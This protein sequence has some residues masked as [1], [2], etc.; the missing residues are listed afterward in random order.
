[1][2]IIKKKGNLSESVFHIIS[3]TMDQKEIILKTSLCVKN[4]LTLLYENAGETLI[5]IL[6]PIYNKDYAK[7]GNLNYVYLNKNKTEV[8]PNFNFFITTKIPKPHYLPETFVALTLVNFTVTEE[9]MEDQILNFVVE[10]E[11][12]QTEKLRKDCIEIVNSFNKKRREIESTILDLLGSGG[13]GDDNESTIL[14]NVELIHT[15]KTS[16]DRAR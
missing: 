12:Y 7:E 6:N 16:K 10:K 4:G 5:S 8:D 3:P 1:M 14:D 15:L 13:K 11:D 9:G 2:N